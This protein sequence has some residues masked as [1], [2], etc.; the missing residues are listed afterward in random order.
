MPA[1]TIP[2]FYSATYSDLMLHEVML[3]AVIRQSVC[4]ELC[5]GTPKPLG[6][7]RRVMFRLHDSCFGSYCALNSA[8]S[9]S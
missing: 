5:A 3:G 9:S 8:V 1:F 6:L 2:H 4:A 7:P